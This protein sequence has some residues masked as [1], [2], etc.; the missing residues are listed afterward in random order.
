MRLVSQLIVVL[1]LDG[2]KSHSTGTE[3]DEPWDDDD[4][5]SLLGI[6]QDDSLPVIKRAYRRLSLEYHPDSAGEAGKD[7]FQKLSRAYEVLSDSNLRRAYDHEGLEGV[8]EYEKRQSVG[9]QHRQDPF[10]AFFG[11]GGNKQNKRPSIEVP[12]FISLKDIFLGKSLEASVFKQT[13]CKKC[14]GTGAK[15]KKDLHKCHHCNG[16]GVVV[17]VHQI[18]HGMYQQVRQ[19]CPHCEGKGKVIGRHC[20][21]CHG[22]KVVAGMESV[23]IE[24]ER[25]MSEGHV[26]TFNNMCDEIAGSAEAPGDISFKVSSIEQAGLRREGNNL[27]LSVNITLKESLLGFT[28]DFEHFDGSFVTL[29]RANKVTPHGQTDRIRSAGMPIFDRVSEYGDLFVLYNVEFPT[30]LTEKQRDAIGDLNLG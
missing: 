7:M 21:H 6:K 22:N 14:R 12:L 30:E 2:G 10:A 1:I 25:G 18:G 8:E 26:I 15:T 11:L 3:D 24:V 19:Q 29:D 5:Y 16:T 23:V 13:R 20:N 17:G 4:L 28:K 9:E 27:H